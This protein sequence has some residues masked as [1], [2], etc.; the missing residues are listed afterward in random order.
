MMMLYKIYIIMLFPTDKQTL[1]LLGIPELL[2]WIL[3]LCIPLAVCLSEIIP[4]ENELYLPYTACVYC[5]SVLILCILS[6]NLFLE[7]LLTS[8]VIQH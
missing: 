1:V 2:L 6:K 5:V 7:F 3:F 4:S 8:L